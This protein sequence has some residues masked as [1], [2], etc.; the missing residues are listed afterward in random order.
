MS[1]LTPLNFLFNLTGSH[2][3]RFCRFAGAG[4][5]DLDCAGHEG[6]FHLPEDAQAGA[7]CCLSGAGTGQ[8]WL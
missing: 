1:E 8:A 5:G 4:A 3:M 2:V 6:L 7:G